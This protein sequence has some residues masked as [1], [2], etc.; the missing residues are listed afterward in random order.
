MFLHGVGSSHHTPFKRPVLVHVVLTLHV[1]G[2]ETLLLRLVRRQRESFDVHVVCLEEAG[3]LAPQFGR[4][5]IA[6]HVLPGRELSL[7]GRLVR[8]AALLRRLRPTVVHTHNLSPHLHTV[9]AYPFLRRV[10]LVHTRHGQHAREHR[11]A[12]IVNWLA[13]RWTRAVIA[14]SEDAA[15]YVT[16]AEAFPRDRVYVVPNG[17]EIDDYQLSS[18]PTHAMIAV[19]RLVPIKGFD[20]LIRA[21]AVVAA[22]SPAATLSIVGDGPERAN[23]ETLTDALGLRRRLRLLGH[24]DDVP[25]LLSQSGMYVIS[26]HSEGLPLTLLEA[27]AARLPVVAAAVGGIPEVVRNRSEAMLVPAGNVERLATALLELIAQPELAGRLAANARARVLERYT[28]E[29]MASRYE[30]IY[31]LARHADNNRTAITALSSAGQL[32][33]LSFADNHRSASMVQWHNTR[34]K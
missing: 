29:A 15:R 7:G 16:D 11:F 2:L 8:F 1:G 30:R 21:F 12:A 27:M 6:V 31:G 22:Q 20:V 14:V 4:V 3:A 32:P 9:L 23:L 17:V 33:R 24:S 25:G 26:S 18:G 34:K 5:G 10:T 28:M 13:G 19:G